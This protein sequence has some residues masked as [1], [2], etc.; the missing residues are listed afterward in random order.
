MRIYKPPASDDPLA[1]ANLRLTPDGLGNLV[2]GEPPTTMVRYSADAC[3]G[4]QLNVIPPG[5]AVDYDYLSTIIHAWLPAPEYVPSSTDKLSTTAG[6]FG[7]LFEWPGL[8]VGFGY[9][10]VTVMDGDPQVS[11]VLNPPDGGVV[12]AIAL[13]DD[14]IP[15]D[16]GIR[17]GA[18]RAQVLAAYPEATLSHDESYYDVYSVQGKHGWLHMVMASEGHDDFDGADIVTAILSSRV[19]AEPW[20]APDY[21]PGMCHLH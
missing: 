12:H 14:T 20:A 15:T 5:A 9:F 2:I 3:L 6:Q 4:A 13:V 11:A 16:R 7:R 8:E 21:V 19:P 18:T 10:D 1:L 17:I